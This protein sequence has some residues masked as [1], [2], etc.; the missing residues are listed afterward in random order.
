[1]QEATD[2]LDENGMSLTEGQLD[3]TAK[4]LLS[5][6]GSLTQSVEATLNNPLWSDLQH[7]LNNEKENY[8]AIFNVLPEDIADI[9]YVECN[10]EEEWAQEATRIV[11]QAVGKKMAKQMQATMAT[12]EDTFANRAIANGQ[13]PYNHSITENGNTLVVL[14]GDS[15][16][17]LNKNLHC[18]T[19]TVKFPPSVT[20]LGVANLTDDTNYRVGIWC[21]GR[22]PFMYTLNFNLLITSGALEL[23]LKYLDGSPIVVNDTLKTI[24]ITTRAAT[25]PASGS[26][27]M[28]TPFESYQILDVHTFQTTAWNIS[29][30][31]EVLNIRPT[32][33]T[34]FV[35]E[36][37]YVFISYQRLP[38]PMVHDHD[39]MFHIKHLLSEKKICFLGTNYI[40][41]SS[42]HL[43]NK[44]G[45]YFVGIGIGELFNMADNSNA[46]LYHYAV[47]VETGYRMYAG[48]DS[49]IYVTLYGTEADEAARELSSSRISKNS[50][51]FNW[52]T[53]ARSLGEIRYLRIWV[54]NSGRGHRESWYCN[55]VFIKDLHTGSIY[56]FPIHDWLG[57]CMG[58]G[59][60]ERLSAA[61]TSINLVNDSMS[62]H[63]LAET[64]SYIAMYTG[65]GLRTRRRISRCSHAIS[66]LFAHYV[67]CL[68]NWAICS[69]EN[70][71]G[72]GHC[73][74]SFLQSAFGI[75]Y[76]IRDVGYALLLSIIILPFTSLLPLMKSK[77]LSYED[78]REVELIKSRD[79]NAKDARDED[80]LP[81]KKNKKINGVVY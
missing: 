54:D 34:S 39:S 16:Y 17:L 9:R 63:I 68:V 24:N 29:I 70:Y 47:A 79:A 23:H 44:T 73:C 32:T 61:E 28:F 74:H 18:D 20:D 14:I 40:Y 6:V 5:V 33:R 21:Y 38:G 11:Q 27:T 25:L 15:N 81:Q 64:I 30:F 45:L 65:G 59:A 26:N 49:K 35:G 76:N 36:E 51:V 2:Y 69:T 56:R 77:M 46:D 78:L 43:T 71:T 60:S 62:I 52:G 37:A 50:S 72:G 12:L 19:W 42:P 31:L 75:S 80:R 3:D 53:T 48:T 13:I 4:N 8:D 66:V 67:V 58:D 1:M 57:Q 41:V 55:R 22:N 7:N 10:S